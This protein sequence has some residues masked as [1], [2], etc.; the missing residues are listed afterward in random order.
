LVAVI[1]PISEY[2]RMQNIVDFL[3]HKEIADIISKREQEKAGFI[4]FEEV[5]KENKIN[6]E[7][8]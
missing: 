5:L 3:E 8:L 4:S 6:D 1:L 2:E 7:D